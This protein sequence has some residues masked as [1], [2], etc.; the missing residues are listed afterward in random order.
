MGNT[1]NN[2]TDT[3]NVEAILYIN[4]L[5]SVIDWAY[6]KLSNMVF[7]LHD[8]YKLFGLEGLKGLYGYY[9]WAR[10]NDVKQ[11]VIEI[12]ITHDIVNRRKKGMTPR[13]ISYAKYTEELA[14]LIVLSGMH[15]TL[16]EIKELSMVLES[17]KDEIIETN[18]RLLAMPL[19][20]KMVYDKYSHI[21]WQVAYNKVIMALNTMIHKL[22]KGGKLLGN[23]ILLNDKSTMPVD[24]MLH[25][26]GDK[27][28]HIPLDDDILLNDKG[29]D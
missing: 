12:N 26:F 20:A 16:T 8:Y 4:K 9:L 21:P 7:V 19:F 10:K 15:T 28:K 25:D 24:T 5:V 6:E 27:G 14:E 11:I 18:H 17:F 22:N 29:G 23:G 2:S 13:T 1:L 3:S